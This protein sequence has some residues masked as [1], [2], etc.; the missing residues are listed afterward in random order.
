M[1]ETKQKQQGR[2]RDVLQTEVFWILPWRRDRNTWKTVLADAGLPETVGGRVR[3]IV[4]R[5]R[6]RRRERLEV[7]REL[8]AHARD[9]LDA[10]VDEGAVVDSLGEPRLVAR[11]IRRAMKRK[12]HWLWHARVWVV[13]TLAGT[14]APALLIAGVLA[15]RIYF[16]HPSPKHNYYAE[17]NAPVL[18]LDE[19]EKAWP[20]YKEARFEI[21]R[22]VAPVREQMRT[23]AADR[24]AQNEHDHKIEVAMA[25]VDLIPTID[26]AHP[27][28]SETVALLEKIRPALELVKRGAARPAVGMLYSSNS[29]PYADQG[30]G[31]IAEPIPEPD[32]V[33]E[34]SLLMNGLLPD[35]SLIRSF[36]RWLAFDAIVAAKRG[37]SGRA[38]DSIRTIRR[39]ARQLDHEPD[40]ISYLVAIAVDS[41]AAVTVERMIEA[42]ADVF[43]RDDLTALAHEI[44]TAHRSVP[45]SVLDSERMMFEDFLQRAFTDDGHGDGHITREG[46]RLYGSMVDFRTNP[47]DVGEV[48]DFKSVS[49]T[50]ASLATLSRTELSKASRDYLNLV[51][52]DL[53][54]GYEVYRGRGFASE[55]WVE[56]NEGRRSLDPVLQL[57]PSFGRAIDSQN[58][59]LVRIDSALAVIAME[60]Y[61]RDSGAWA[62]SFDVLVPRYLPLAPE[63]PFTGDPLRL[64]ITDDG[65]VIYSVGPDRDDDGGVSG[66]LSGRVEW[67][68]LYRMLQD[69][70]DGDWVLYPP[71]V[72]AWR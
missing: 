21:E 10:G 71:S 14:V 38:V 72:T 53:D 66:E 34:Q 2:I 51:R 58:K 18:A 65:P 28:Y 32:D 49:D 3:E 4:R 1:S 59:F 30:P 27:D 31:W 47:A 29:E 15:G 46:F 60:Q 70:P 6:L 43:S 68:L 11:L 52:S 9:A 12:R 42:H 50:V 7:A 19:D 67:A 8:I 20:L 35:L 5:T 40:L 17:L 64:K 37:D 45:A 44:S 23:E 41:L 56:S 33:A 48:M 62:G 22:V 26:P 39:L 61:R 24:I 54:A 36:S 13:R 55:R 16:S 69:P 63:D 57:I 25:G